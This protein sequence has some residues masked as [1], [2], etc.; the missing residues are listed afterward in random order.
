MAA[1]QPRTRP[2]LN[3][4]AANS[5]SRAATVGAS[6]HDGT[7]AE[8]SRSAAAAASPPLSVFLTNLR[9]LDLDLL[10]D[11]P[12]I[13]IDT[14]A[15]TG[16]QGQKRRI[17]CVEWVLVKLFG[18]W[19]PEETCSKLH[20]FFPPQDQMQSVSLRA[21]L[22][23][24]LDTLKKNGFLGRD[25][26]IRKTMLDECK[27]ERLEEVLACF[28][29][30]VL[31]RVVQEDAKVAAPSRGQHHRPVAVK[32]ALETRGYDS[33][34]NDL[35]ALNLA[36]RSSLRRL[37]EQREEE[38][39]LY[40]DFGDLLGVKERGLRR[41]MEAVRA[42]ESGGAAQATLSNNARE[43]MR[44]LVNNNWSG[45]EKWMETLIRG[46][47]HA[48]E[49]TGLLGMPFDR[50]WRRVQ[51]GRL[52]EI[53]Q[54]SGGLLE[55]LDG[56]VKL[57]TD[58]L[59]RWNA[60]RNSTFG[61]LAEPRVSSPSKKR[62]LEMRR[63]SRGIDFEFSS[64]HDLHVGAAACH[65][66]LG[67]SHWDGEDKLES[68][69]SYRQ[70]LSGLEDDLAGIKKVDS[71]V[72][73]FLAP[74]GSRRRSLADSSPGCQSTD[75]GETISEMS[76]F[77]DE[78]SYDGP[79][80]GAM[81]A[82]IPV[83]TNRMR[84]DSL[85]RHPIKP[86]MPSSD[87]FNRSISTQSSSS[88]PRDEDLTLRRQDFF[89]PPTDE[90]EELEPPPSPPQ[91]SAEG[92]LEAMDH[93]SPSPIKRSRQRPMLSLAQRTRLS[94]AGNQ[95]PFLDEEPELPPRRP[96]M[97]RNDDAGPTPP[98][99]PDSTKGTS[100]AMDLVGRTRLSMANFEQA[101]KKAH[102]ERRKSLRKSKGPPRRDVS[103]AEKEEP[104]QDAGLDHEALTQELMMEEDMEAVFKSR[105]K[106]KTS[107]VGSPGKGW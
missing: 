23:R 40:R 94:M 18:I 73:D 16:V 89:I 57:Q 102:F 3:M 5:R 31:K 76:E 91:D 7:C 88:P 24:A 62:E 46:D 38:R 49:T 17:K 6:N 104:R 19:D 86:H 53:E 107:P 100:E 25:S 9:L 58:R 93:A 98:S 75:G 92:I 90:S 52:A 60:F 8:T 41:R 28:S 63:P 67:T 45:N 74:S 65:A 35:L 101:Q 42:K 106:I 85:R 55:Q 95:S 54:D 59:A 14:F 71:A 29:T 13:T 36:Y 84:L 30:A 11:W 79:R 80:A 105:P 82:A 96:L 70:L 97:P 66:T 72:L 1:V 33:N 99:E 47:C 21:A 68:S 15:T 103:Y 61:Q 39:A 83:R 51:Q 81:T 10:P 87:V 34:N 2:R 44:R 69:Q 20:P 78:H 64:H 43:E 56:R 32:L 22:L 50:V 4:A 48:G 12:D 26:I 37:L 27:G 77:E